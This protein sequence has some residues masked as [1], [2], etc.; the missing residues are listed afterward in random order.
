MASPSAP[1]AYAELAAHSLHLVV[2]SGRKIVAARAFPLEAKNDLAAFVAEHQLG[3][4]ARASYLGSKNYL[5]RSVDTESAS[6]RQPAALATHAAKLPHGFDS[7]PVAVVCDAAAGTAPDPARPAPWVLAAVGGAA[8][9]AAKEALAAL[10]LTPADLTLAAPTHLGAVG[11]SLAAGETALVVIPGDDEAALVWVG[12]G[13][14]QAVAGGPVGY[15]KIFEAVQH[16]LGL[17]FKAAAGKLFYN[18]N[19]DFSE[20]APKIAAELAEALKPALEGRPAA[21]LHIAGLTPGQAW[22][23]QGLGSALG[24]KAWAPAGAALCARYGLE[25]PVLALPGTAAGLVAL[26]G[27]PREDAPWVRPTLDVLISRQAARPAAAAPAPTAAAATP[28]VPGAAVAKTPSAPAPVSAKSTAPKAGTRPPVPA[29]APNPK[30]V[31]K[32]QVAGA[33]A[34]EIK[35]GGVAAPAAPA[36]KRNQGPIWIAGG[37]TLAALVVGLAAHFRS[38]K[39]GKAGAPPAPVAPASAQASAGAVSPPP[40]APPPAP[41]PEPP[42]PTVS[43]PVP[44]PVTKS[45]VGSF[46]HVAGEARRFANARYQFEVSAKGF[47]QALATSRAE[48][49]VES[50]AGIGLQGSSVGADGRRKWFN[51]GVVD[52][53]GYGA[54]VKKGVRDGHT[55]FDVKVSHPRFEL[56][57]TFTC[58]EDRVQVAAH[59]KPLDLVDPRGTI[60]AI[61]AVRL[62]PVALNPAQ[63][64]RPSPGQFAY[65]MKSGPLA[66]IFDAAKWARDGAEGKEVIMAGEN[67]VNFYF[68]DSAEGGDKR[69]IYEI[70]MP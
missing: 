64:M 53:P 40:P 62:S 31:A 57:Q 29:P 49:L 13:G 37:V 51:V 58:L 3:G 21:V 52:D 41:D 7:T 17:K 43:L 67:G 14:V 16:G 65:A 44:A 9:A 56:E 23:V 61:H 25:A 28:A 32:P 30:T 19:Y 27:S 26:A 59:F 38:P 10:G 39:E 6:V 33:P 70:L 15:G 11:G 45:S 36:P 69:L 48:V 47:I 2:I 50:A 63:R 68:P 60:T 20:A 5:H 35:S 34:G 55:V 22:L 4:V 42:A 12:A 46:D 54:E 24:L 8:F 66:V 18:D 1:L